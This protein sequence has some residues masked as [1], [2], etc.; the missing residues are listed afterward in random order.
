MRNGK[1]L[2][3]LAVFLLSLAMSAPAMSDYILTKDVLTSAGGQVSSASY[4]LGYSVGQTVAGFSQGES[5]AEWAGFWGGGSWGQA[6]SAPEE[7][8]AVR[9]QE[10][11]LHQNYPNPFNPRTHITYQLPQAGQVS[12]CI[13]NVRGQLVIRLMDQ[14]QLSGEHSATWDG[15]D[16]YGI[17]VASGIYFCHLT[18]GPFQAVRKMLFLK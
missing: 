17:P 12:L 1:V 15:R 5:H 14:Y 2:S 9:P 3:A 7:I 13:Y 6:T 8:R 11:L 10:Y 18:A 16:G 4:L